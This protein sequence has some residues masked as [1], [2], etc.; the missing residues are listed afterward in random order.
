MQDDI[1][2]DTFLIEINVGIAAVLLKTV[3]SEAR[4]NIEELPFYT[5]SIGNEC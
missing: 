3:S 2:L 1:H 4:F 5:Q